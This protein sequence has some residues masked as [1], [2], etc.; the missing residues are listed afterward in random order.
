[1]HTGSSLF[2]LLPFSSHSLEGVSAQGQIKPPG[3]MHGRSD[4]MTVSGSNEESHC[5][6]PNGFLSIVL[7]LRGDFFVWISSYFNVSHEVVYLPPKQYLCLRFRQWS[8]HMMV[9]CISGQMA[10]AFSLSN[11]LFWSRFAFIV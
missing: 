1:M 2:F 8:L 6:I 9:A 7:Y 4:G 5:V 11:C 10:P 3:A